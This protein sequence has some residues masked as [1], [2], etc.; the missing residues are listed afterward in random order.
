ML[1]DV[2]KDEIRQGHT[3]Q[4]AKSHAI[5]EKPGHF[6]WLSALQP[7]ASLSLQILGVY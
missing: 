5:S 6:R 7:H 2:A 1:K 3:N 4:V